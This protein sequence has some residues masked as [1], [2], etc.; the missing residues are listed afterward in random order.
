MSGVAGG[1]QE[2]VDKAAVVFDEHGDFIRQAIAFQVRSKAEVDDLYQDLFLSLVSRPIPDDV[3]NPK[4]Y[5]YRAVARDATDCA[6]RASRYRI[7]MAEYA[8]RQASA[9]H[10]M[11][12]S[13]VLS[14]AEETDKLFA[15]F[16]KVLAPSESRAVFLRYAKDCNRTE[17]AEKMGVTPRSVSQYVSTAVRKLRKVLGDNGGN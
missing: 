5:L 11:S 6:R 1:S 7:R 8:K 2:A 14:K 9:P 13:E 10:V 12:A 17:A 4:S 15:S 3:R 16:T